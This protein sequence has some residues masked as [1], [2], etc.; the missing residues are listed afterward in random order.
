MSSHATESL[1]SVRVG[2]RLVPLV[3]RAQ[4]K[5]CCSP[6]RLMIE[7]LIVDG[8]PPSEII[9]RLPDDSTLNVRNVQEHR[10]RGHLPID[11]ETVREVI[12]AGR[13]GPITELVVDA[14]VKVAADQHIAQL[15]VDRVF[16]AVANDE[17]ELKVR[18]GL[19]ASQ[20]LLDCERRSGQLRE[21]RAQAAATD[22]HRLDCLARVFELAGE[23]GGEAL[24]SRLLTRAEK[25]PLVGLLMLDRRLAHLR[26][27][28]EHRP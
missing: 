20:F 6:H 17:L 9:S 24:M 19:R 10:R 22:D 27:S 5:V 23:E 25:D 12:A 7:R 2:D 11:H 28:S 4:C 21:L 1:A 3:H 18:D 8:I 14:T 15:V 26:A 16:K 13:Q